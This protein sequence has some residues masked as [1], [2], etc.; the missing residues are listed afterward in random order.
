MRT[1]RIEEIINILRDFPN[2]KFYVQ[3]GDEDKYLTNENGSIVWRGK[4]QSGQYCTLGDIGELYCE[5]LEPMGFL[6]VANVI[7]EKGNDVYVKVICDLPTGEKT[8]E[9]YFD[10]I[11]YILQ[12]VHGSYTL[13][14]IFSEG[15]WFV[16]LIR[17]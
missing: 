6:E 14:R 12:D 9:G 4:I 5:L 16:E 2:R 3:G 15:Q 7:K 17:N 1:Y 13:A 10:D 8:Y 11:I